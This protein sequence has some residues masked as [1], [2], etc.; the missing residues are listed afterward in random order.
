MIKPDTLLIVKLGTTLGTLGDVK[1]FD[2]FVQA[3]ELL[4]STGVPAQESQKIDH[5]LGEVATLA[6]AARHFARLGVV[7]FQREDRET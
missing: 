5:C 7:P 3:E 6:V 1:G 4:L 2:E